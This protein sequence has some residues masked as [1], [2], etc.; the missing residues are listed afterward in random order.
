MISRA[1]FNSYFPEIDL[2]QELSLREK[3]YEAFADAMEMG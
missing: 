2:I 1:R 3:T